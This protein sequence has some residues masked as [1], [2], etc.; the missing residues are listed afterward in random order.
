[1]NYW[2]MGIIPGSSTP[3]SS[4]AILSTPISSGDV[5]STQFFCALILVN[6]LCIAC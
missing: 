4:T 1:M 2:F 6:P 5:S 3:V